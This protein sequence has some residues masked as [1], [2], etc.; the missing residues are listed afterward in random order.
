M[1][2]DHFFIVCLS[3][4]AS[5]FNM[6]AYLNCQYMCYFEHSCCTYSIFLTLTVPFPFIIIFLGL[7]IFFSVVYKISHWD[8]SGI[9]NFPFILICQ[10]LSF[11]LISHLPP[12][13]LTASTT[14][15]FEK[16]ICLEDKHMLLNQLSNLCTL[17]I[18]G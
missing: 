11:C 17:Q 1:H 13:F 6:L 2:G 18:E 4:H 15:L 12:E 8:L 9:H 10:N 3:L 14:Q 7:I 16:K 5:H